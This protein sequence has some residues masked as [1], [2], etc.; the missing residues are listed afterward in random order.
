MTRYE[1]LLTELSERFHD[2]TAVITDTRQV[3]Y[4]QLERLALGCSQ[5]L[6]E[7]G[8]VPGRPS[9]VMAPNSLAFLVSYFGT[10]MSGAIVTCVDPSAPKRE[11]E[12]IFRVTEPASAILPRR[13]GARDIAV[14]LEG[15][16]P[17]N[18]VWID[19]LDVPTWEEESDRSLIVPRDP[20]ST[21]FLAFT[22]GSTGQPKGALHRTDTLL[23]TSRNF[24]RS[25]LQDQAFISASTFPMYNMGGICMILPVLMGG[26]TIVVVPGFTASTL[27][28]AI[29]E[30]GVS[31]AVMT[32]AMAEL[33]FLKGDLGNHDVSAFTRMLL[34]AA[35]ISNQ[36]CRR[37]ADELGM[38]VYI[39]Y[40]L[41]EVPGGWL[42]TREDTPI[43]EIGQF[44]GWPMEG[45]ELAILDDDGNHL[46]AS[47]AGEICI[48]TVYRLFAYI[49]DAASTAALI[50][51]DGW[52]HTGDMG[53]LRDDGGLEI[54][55]RKKDM[56]IR[57]GFNVY[58]REVEEALATHPEVS[59]AAVHAVDDPVLGEKGF[60]WIVLEP[61]SRLS[62][63]ELRSYTSEHLAHYK[64]PDFFRITTDLPMI[65]AGKVDK[66]HLRVLADEQTVATSAQ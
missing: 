19:D 32:P 31:F 29:E 61:G 3:S 56:Y 37:L 46:A 30:H 52:I 53:T 64:V 16:L 60:A 59:L 27:V 10:L 14:E 8:V 45:Y 6:R 25:V 18:V 35:P 4:G 12:G 11:L 34:C 62:I 39:A 20:G 22:S 24:A 9:I 66:A 38:S 1:E 42:T 63:D 57:G 26:G 44:V 40:G 43:E 5:R 15:L 13:I 33:F 65:A 7:A 28:R 51:D 49:N 58:P 2:R 48:R 17:E 41:T 55:G 50:D 47:Q 36:L 21:G 23:H 54:R